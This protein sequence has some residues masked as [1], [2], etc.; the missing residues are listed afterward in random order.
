[1]TRN[2]R[3]QR[4]PLQNRSVLGVKGK[5]PGFSYR[6]VNDVGDRI[7]SFKARGYEVVEDQ[8]VQVGDRRVAIPTR[9]GSPVQVSVGGGTKGYLMRI[10]DEWYKEDQATKEREL[11]EL[12]KSMKPASSDYGSIKIDRDK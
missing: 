9:E 5:E 8:T 6:I 1:M 12:E 10:K 3:P 4:T 2:T 7:E 11:Q